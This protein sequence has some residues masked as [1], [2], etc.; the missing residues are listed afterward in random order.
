MIPLNKLQIHV[1]LLK[2]IY[3]VELF[4]SLKTW[5]SEH[6]KLHLYE[7]G[8]REIFPRLGRIWQPLHCDHLWLKNRTHS[9]KEESNKQERI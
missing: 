8:E 3:S 1:L 2:L 7:S 5:K 9:L 6:M 4:F